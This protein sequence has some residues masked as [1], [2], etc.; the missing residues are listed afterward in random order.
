MWTHNQGTPFAFST[1]FLQI[2]NQFFG[3]IQLCTRRLVAVKVAH[4]T[5]TKRDIVQ[6]ITVYVASINLSAPS[7]PNFDLAVA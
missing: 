6:I 5:N 3:C 2:P 1:A 7:I 4:Q